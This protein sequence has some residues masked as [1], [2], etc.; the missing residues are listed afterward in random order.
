MEKN[1]E[2]S[3]RKELV[4]DTGKSW[5]QAEGSIVRGKVTIGKGSS[6]WYN[7]VVRADVN[8]I[9]IGENSNVQDN[10][11]LHVSPWSPLFIGNYVTIGHGAILH[12]CEVHDNTLI[13][14]G[15]ILMNGAE[16][17]KNCI[18][19]AGA[20]VTQNMKIPDNS[21]ALGNPAKV[22]RTL[23]QEEIEKNHWYAEE[24]LED[25]QKI[26]AEQVLE[27]DRR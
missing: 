23:T 6:I 20:L 11:V 1:N 17:G 5:F 18:I 8:T 7:A 27:Q 21:L 13:G 10:C 22:V 2:N 26:K 3:Q 12:G 4:E 9:T 19:G 15:S 14:M 24:Y 25:V 16:I